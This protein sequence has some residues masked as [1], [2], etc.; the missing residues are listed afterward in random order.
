MEGFIEE[1]EHDNY[2]PRIWLLK[3]E[4]KKKLVVRKKITVFPPVAGGVGCGGV[5]WVI[6]LVGTSFLSI[7]PWVF[8]RGHHQSLVI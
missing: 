5:G 2:K 4:E 8:C 1:G 3:S 7:L 6:T